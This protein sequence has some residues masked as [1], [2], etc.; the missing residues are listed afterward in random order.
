MNPEFS[1]EFPLKKEIEDSLSPP[2]INH[3]L[4]DRSEATNDSS[5]F[6]GPFIDVKAEPKEYEHDEGDKKYSSEID[7]AMNDKDIPE[8][9]ME[10]DTEERNSGQTGAKLFGCKLCGKMFS[11]NYKLTVHMRIHNGEKPY[12]CG[13]CKKAFSEK[14]NLTKHMKVHTGEK[15]FTCAECGKTFSQKIHLRG[16]MLTHTGEKPFP[17]T[18]CGRAF[19]LKGHVKNHMRICT[20]GKS[21]GGTRNQNASA[22]ELRRALRRVKRYTCVECGKKFSRKPILR[23]HMRIHTGEKPFTCSECGKAFSQKNAVTNHMR[24]HT[25]E[26]PFTCRECGKSFSR[27]GSLTSHRKI[28]TIRDV[29]CM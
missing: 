10:V 5:L 8:C 17:C 4:F 27:K 11:R 23:D 6:L 26:K 19:A 25:G 20:G 22:V 2:P 12:R 7:M 29:I 15:P 1:V 24:T 18:V 9:K 14:S 13:E 3:D 21:A 16:H 28:H